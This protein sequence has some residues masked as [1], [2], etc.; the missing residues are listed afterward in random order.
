LINAKGGKGLGFEF[1]STLII[2]PELRVSANLGYVD[3]KISGPTLIAD[4]RTAGTQLDIS[5]QPFPFAAK[6]TGSVSAEYDHALGADDAVF[7]ATD[8]SYRGDENF[9]LTSGVQPNLRG[10]GYW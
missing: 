7:L 1:E 2:T 6:W 10:K 8:W 3:T 9:S 4:P 5:G